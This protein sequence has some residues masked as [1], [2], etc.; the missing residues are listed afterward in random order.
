MIMSVCGT[1]SLLTHEELQFNQPRID[2]IIDL[3]GAPYTR[4]DHFTGM[5][6]AKVDSI[7]FEI[8]SREYFEFVEKG[9][10]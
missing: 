4:D 10:T 2:H 3:I 7:R 9:I 1:H 6:T 8:H 5:K